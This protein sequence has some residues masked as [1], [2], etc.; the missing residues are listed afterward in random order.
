MRFNVEKKGIWSCQWKV[1]DTLKW[2]DFMTIEEMR[3]I[4]DKYSEDIS[5]NVIKIVNDFCKNICS[6]R[7]PS[8]SLLNDI[9]LE[10]VKEL[11]NNYIWFVKSVLVNLPDRNKIRYYL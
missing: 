8:N 5:E 4:K 6:G 2:S 7:N 1:L 11:G 9:C 10:V 3:I